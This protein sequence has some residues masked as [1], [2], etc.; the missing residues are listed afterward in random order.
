MSILTLPA[1]TAPDA[2]NP[3]A[4]RTAP[5]AST[6]AATPGSQPAAATPASGAVVPSK[7]RRVKLCTYLSLDQ[8]ARVMAHVAKSGV[9]AGRLFREGAMRTVEEAELAAVPA[10]A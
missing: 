6:T 9:P 1:A 4:G 2:I 7:N 5:G 10:E 3:A 8:Y